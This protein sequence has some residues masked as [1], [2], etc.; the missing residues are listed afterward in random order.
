M[1]V[2]PGHVCAHTWGSQ[3]PGRVSRSRCPVPLTPAHGLAVTQS[4][5]GAAFIFGLISISAAS[6]R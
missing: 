5:A 3:T 2:P 6:S 4:L 1:S